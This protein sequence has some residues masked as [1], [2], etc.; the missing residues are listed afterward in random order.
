MH[1]PVDPDDIRPTRSPAAV[2]AELGAEAN[3]PVVGAFAHL[4]LKKGHRELVHAA[5]LVLRRAPAAQ[6]WCFGE[7]PL[8]EELEAT[9]R[10]LGI[11]DRF[12]VFGFRRDVANLLRAI[13]VMC[14]PSHR[15]PFGQV[16]VEA[17]LAE[18]PVIACKAGGAPEI[19][20]HGET[21]LLVPPPE[22][23]R[24]NRPASNIG[25]LAD[26][27]LTLFDNRDLAAAMGRRGRAL[28][29]QRFGWPQYLAGLTDL[30]RCI[31]GH[32]QTLGR[33]AA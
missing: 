12:R 23:P 11:G 31:L 4:S 6:F 8:R 26:A 28:A 25:A 19:V 30:Y 2:R 15:E 14:L 27:I 33:R 22:L 16:Y 1:Y 13:D 32:D 24:S 21:G 18:K 5:E 7:G 20:V 10:M 9:A 17:A 29:L 3:T